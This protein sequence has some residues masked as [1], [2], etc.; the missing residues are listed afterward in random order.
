MGTCERFRIAKE[1]EKKQQRQSSVV[2]KGKKNVHGKPT[3]QKQNQKGSKV[4]GKD[5][6][7]SAALFARKQS[8][9][10]SADATRKQDNDGSNAAG[11]DITGSSCTS[12][13][14][15]CAP[16]VNAKLL[17]KLHSNFHARMEAKRCM[18]HQRPS[19]ITF[20]LC[21]SHSMQ[22]VHTCCCCSERVQL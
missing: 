14:P 2:G 19:H 6:H 20:P 13:P 21:R 10:G 4:V 17:N 11:G 8:I 18:F 9:D 22:P 3:M 15:D 5:S 1:D 12:Y 16:R 7:E